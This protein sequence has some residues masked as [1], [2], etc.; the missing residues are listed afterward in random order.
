MGDLSF[1]LPE[2]T[3]NPGPSLVSIY[4]NLE[5]QRTANDAG[6]WFPEKMGV[7][8]AVVLDGTQTRIFTEKDISAL[9]AVLESAERVIGYNLEGFDLKVLSGYPEID[10]GRIRH[11]DLLQD[12]QRVAEK[13]VMLWSAVEATLGLTTESDGIQMVKCWKNG[14]IEK[15]IDHCSSVTRGIKALHEYGREHG[16]VFYSPDED[17]ERLR[18]EVKW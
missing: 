3:T 2:P 1:P 6:G 5:T 12:L 11:L 15:V 8:V 4:L 17:G 16:H 18:L 14:E 9:A 7:S 10:L 13:R